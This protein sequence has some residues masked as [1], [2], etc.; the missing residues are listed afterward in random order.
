MFLFSVLLASLVSSCVIEDPSEHNNG[1]HPMLFEATSLHIIVK[2]ASGNNIT[3][4]YMDNTKVFY[5]LECGCEI[6][7]EPDYTPG[8]NS[9]D[10]GYDYDSIHNELLLDLF[11][12]R[13][14][15]HNGETISTY[16]ILEPGKNTILLNWNSYDVDTVVVKGGMKDIETCTLAG[17]DSIWYNGTVIK[18]GFDDR[19]VHPYYTKNV[20]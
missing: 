11:A 14:H 16:E 1:L 9:D 12:V 6:F 10:Y 19:V 2:D 5:K 3:Q 18:N 13:T 15:D 20:K 17:G 8:G 7:I 4:D